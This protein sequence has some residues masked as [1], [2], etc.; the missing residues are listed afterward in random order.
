[1]YILIL[2]ESALPVSWITNVSLKRVKFFYL[3][4]YIYICTFSH[5]YIYTHGRDI[6]SC[7][8]IFLHLMLSQ[9]G[10]L[11]C[12]DPAC[13]RETSKMRSQWE[14]KN[15][16][17]TSV[18][19]LQGQSLQSSLLQGWL[20]SVYQGQPYRTKN[21]SAWQNC[22]DVRGDGSCTACHAFYWC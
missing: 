12:A 3:H 17:R 22:Q 8:F 10:I 4:I 13:L 15:F 18:P 7:L 20:C 6:N 2:W 1:M 9:K 16:D 11:C 5:L 19:A 14:R 21:T